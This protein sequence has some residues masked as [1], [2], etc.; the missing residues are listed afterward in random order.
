MVLLSVSKR[1]GSAEGSVIEQEISRCEVLGL[2][3]GR[4]GSCG[5]CVEGGVGYVVEL[6]AGCGSGLFFDR[7]G[8]GNCLG[9]VRGVDGGVGAGCLASVLEA[10]GGFR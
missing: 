5:V 6:A 4:G 9:V 7:F 2:V 10:S 8:G 1:T 3:C